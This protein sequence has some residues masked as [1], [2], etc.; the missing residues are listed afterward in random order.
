MLEQSPSSAVSREDLTAAETAERVTPRLLVIDDDNLHRMIICRA[1]A[2]AG[3]LP[4]GAATYDEAVKLLQG[5][6]FDCVALDLSLG[7][8]AGAE[9]LRYFWV[10]GC[11]L[12][13]IIMS[14]GDDATCS[15]GESIANSLKLNIWESISKPVD[16]S[17]LRDSLE[18]LKA[19][20]DGGPVEG[21]PSA[22]VSPA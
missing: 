3:Y 17:V 10:I 2:K 5:T 4:A 22:Q 15:E 1:A 7:E 6:T 21:Q 18:R 13:I 14:A 11:K 8:H 19:A 12:P 20:R 16:V 9:M